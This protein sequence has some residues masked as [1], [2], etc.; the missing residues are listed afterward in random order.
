LAFESTTAS[1]T[2]A[3][4]TYTSQTSLDLNGSKDL[5][6]GLTNSVSGGSGF[7]SLHLEIDSNFGAIVSQT[8]S[9]L[10]SAQA[11]FHD[12]LFVLG[13]P[14]STVDLTITMAY[15]S[16]T[17]GATFG[18]TLLT[19]ISVPGDLNGDGIVNG[20][21]IN[22]VATHWLQTGTRLTVPGD[23]NGDGI[24]NGL[25]IQLIATNWLQKVGGGGGSSANATSVPEPSTSLLALF[26]VAIA[27]AW[28]R[29]ASRRHAS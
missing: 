10:S 3:S 21:D 5:L 27:L 13:S 17:P 9:T 11:Y 7:G 12:H 26:G 16:A 18:A 22:E 2:G 20:L 28:R 8:F 6:L 25:D 29:R 19:G 24:T 14:D 23:A 1:T 4:A 15:T